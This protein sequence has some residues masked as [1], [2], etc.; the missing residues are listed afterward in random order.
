MKLNIQY[1][2]VIA[3]GLWGA[4]LSPPALGQTGEGD[5][6]QAIVKREFGTSVEE[7]TAI[8]KQIQNAKPEAEAL[9]RHNESRY[10]G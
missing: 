7:M 3:L 5:I 2:L 6:Y 9:R 1:S 4:R 10:L 8:E